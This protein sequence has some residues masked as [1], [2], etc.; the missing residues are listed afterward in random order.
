M[1]NRK[2]AL[3]VRPQ[4]LRWAIGSAGWRDDELARATGIDAGL[5]GRWQEHDSEISLAD[6]GKIAAKIKRPLSAFMLPEPPPEPP[7][8]G[9][10]PWRES[11]GA[12][13]SKRL[14]TAMRLAREIQYNARE[15][16]D[17]APL[18]LTPPAD[19][20]T[21]SHTDDPEQVAGN[22]ATLMGLPTNAGEHGPASA[23]RHARTKYLYDR[24][25]NAVESRGVFVAQ[26]GFPVGEAKGFAITGRGPPVILVNADDA[27]NSRI[28]TLFH[29]YAHVLLDGG[30][31][32]CP[33]PESLD[34]SDSGSGKAIEGWCDV[35]A[36][37]ILMPRG[38][39]L[40]VL[41]DLKGHTVDKILA[42]LS[43]RFLLSKRAVLVRA[44]GLLEGSAARPYLTHY[45]RLG[46]PRLPPKPTGGGSNSPAVSCLSG[47]GRRYA[48]LVV[49][50]EEAGIITESDMGM[51]LDLKSKHFN[52]LRTKAWGG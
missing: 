51:Y 27:I 52:A 21:A 9:F 2:I 1:D 41:N 3:K 24:L 22:E 12:P 50:M 33:A 13:P 7:V 11:P 35:F 18:D 39:F 38:K 44:I 29:E 4:V 23:T 37:S 25:R 40:S 20:A 45:G 5:I 19:N 26:A 14:C 6:I 43:Q 30:S 31:L 32:C 36:A 8:A 28:F 48:R 47:R 34:A 15:L 17:D 49:D 42:D 16:L 10:M 46:P